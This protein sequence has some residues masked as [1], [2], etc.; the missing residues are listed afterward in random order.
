VGSDGEEDS[1]KTGRVGASTLEGFKIVL[2]GFESFAFSADQ[3][4]TQA[5][6]KTAAT[7]ARS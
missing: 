3:D 1:G 7:E 5:A 4:P 6:M 2:G